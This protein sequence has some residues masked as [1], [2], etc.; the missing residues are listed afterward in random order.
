VSTVRGRA[1]SDDDLDVNYRT[2]LPADRGARILDVG[3]GTGRLMRYLVDQG[4]A[5]VHGVDNDADVVAS[6]RSAVSPNVSV[7]DD[8]AGWLQSRPGEFDLIV[9]RQ[10]IY[11]LPPVR[12]VAALT[13]ARSALSAHGSIVVEVFNAAT[14]TGPVVMHKDLDILCAY[15]EHSLRDLLQR[16][17]FSRI[18]VVG[19][20]DAARGARRAAFLA[21]NR[22]WRAALR[23][24]YTAER[25]LD[26][27]NPRILSRNLLAVGRAG[28]TGG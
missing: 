17:G 12:A 25:G 5:D 19:S 8:L 2:L 13:A 27:Q 16:A 7:T 26:P 22:S 11:Y 20:R 18:E 9:A 21:L 14:L 24:I 10:M 6:T 1:R 23:L 4:Y 3:C 28:A 15:T